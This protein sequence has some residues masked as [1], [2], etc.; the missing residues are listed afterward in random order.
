MIRNFWKTFSYFRL[1][2]LTLDPT[3]FLLHNVALLTETPEMDEVLR[4]PFTLIT[5]SMHCL[6]SP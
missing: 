5:Y 4:L 1:H 3:G 2:L 6:P